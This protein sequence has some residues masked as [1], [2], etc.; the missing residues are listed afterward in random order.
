MQTSIFLAVWAFVA[1]LLFKLATFVLEDRRHRKNERQL[2][3]ERPPTM[4]NRD[5]LGIVNVIEIFKADKARRIPDYIKERAENFEK[6]TGKVMGTF[7]QKL[8]GTPGIFTLDPKNVQAVLATQ[9]K[10]FGLGELRN[11]VFSPLL[12]DG[13]VSGSTFGS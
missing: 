9:F 7:S 11:K 13:I 8:L 12:G 6:R 10:D 2:G 5:G 3:C 4:A 1:F